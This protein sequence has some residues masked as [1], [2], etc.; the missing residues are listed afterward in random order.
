MNAHDVGCSGSLFFE[1]EI[2]CEW[3]STKEAARFLSLSEN[4]IRIMIHYVQICAY[5]LGR[6]LR[7]KREDCQS[8]IQKKGT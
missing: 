2:K 7:F 3:V 4:A 8:L 1:N 6:R 5:K